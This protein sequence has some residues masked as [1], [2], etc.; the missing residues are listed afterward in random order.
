MGHRHSPRPTAEYTACISSI[1]S[2]R[3]VVHLEEFLGSG[4]SPVL[5]WP[6]PAHLWLRQPALLHLQV[7]S[8]QHSRSL[9]AGKGEVPGSAHLRGGVE[10]SLRSAP[11]G[12]R[13]F[14]R[15]LCI[16]CL[17]G[18][19]TPRSTQTLSNDLCQRRLCPGRPA[20]VPIVCAITA[21][22]STARAAMNSPFSQGTLFDPPSIRCKSERVRAS[23]GISCLTASLDLFMY[24]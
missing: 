20:S 8:G 14:L 18:G 7:T 5:P 3:R 16:T 1:R 11:R 15:S 13:A 24:A 12:R 23:V 6:V 2:T 19:L 17:S 9:R 21:D 4:H 22:E 10:R